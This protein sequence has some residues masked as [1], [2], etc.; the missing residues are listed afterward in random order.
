MKLCIRIQ[1]E[2]GLNDDTKRTSRCIAK[3]SVWIKRNNTQKEKNLP[4]FV[5]FFLG[6][7]T[8]SNIFK[9]FW[10][11]LEKKNCSEVDIP[12]IPRYVVRSDWHAQS[13]PIAGAF[14]I[15]F[16]IFSVAKTRLCWFFSCV[17]CIIIFAYLHKELKSS[18]PIIKKSHFPIC[19]AFTCSSSWYF[20]IAKYFSSSSFFFFSFNINKLTKLIWTNIKSCK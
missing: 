7:K 17:L 4:F 10:C 2:E 15:D 5:F 8:R 11:N 18:I 1:D 19:S 14:I 13:Y 12:L 20:I 9:S 3:V 16:A 6:I